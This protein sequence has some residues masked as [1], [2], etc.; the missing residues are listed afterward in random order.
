[1][2]MRDKTNIQ[3]WLKIRRMNA[4]E[5]AS[6]AHREQSYT[7]L[8]PQVVSVGKDF[9]T[10]QICKFSRIMDQETTQE[11]AFESVKDLVVKAL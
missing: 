3:L 6:L 4:V 2:T 10:G 1:M 9:E 7:I 11:Q 5:G 8:T